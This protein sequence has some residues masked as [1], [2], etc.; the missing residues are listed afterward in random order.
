MHI[1]S[2][3]REDPMEEEMTIHP[4]ILAWKILWTEESGGLQSAAAKSL[5]SCPTLCD[6][7]SLPLGSMESPDSLLGFL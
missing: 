1:P 7:R 3:G 2:L 6:P 5:Q 4:S